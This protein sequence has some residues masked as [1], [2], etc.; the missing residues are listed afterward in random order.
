MRCLLQYGADVIAVDIP[1]DRVWQRL[2]GFAE[3]GAGTLHV[4]VQPDGSDGCDG[5]RERLELLEHALRR[6]PLHR[7]LQ[8]VTSAAALSRRQQQPSIGY[9][10]RTRLN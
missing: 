7:A 2:E 10:L 3:A 5:E 9:W 8:P 4:P 6:Q 1:S